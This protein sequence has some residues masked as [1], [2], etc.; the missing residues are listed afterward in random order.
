MRRILRPRLA[1][2]AAILMLAG[3]VFA[4]GSGSKPAAPAAS[5]AAGTVPELPARKDL[6]NGTGS[7]GYVVLAWNDLGMHCLNPSYDA[8]VILPPYNTVV[9]QV[10]KRGNPPQPVTSGLTVSYRILGNTRSSNKGSYGQFWVYAQKLFGETLPLDQGLNLDDPTVH[11]GLSGTMLAKEDHFLASGIPVTPIN[12]QGVWN[13]Y[14]VGEITVKDASGRVLA[15]TTATV[16]TSDE[17]NCAKCHGKDA[18]NEVL[19]QH[20]TAHGTRLFANRPVLC[21]SCHGSPVLGT[22]G[23]GTSGM[24]LSQ[25][26]H[27]SHATRGAACYDCHP[28][29]TTRCSRS[30]AH[31]AA[32]GNCMACHGDMANV[33]NTIKSGT[34]IPWAQ[35]PK[36]VTCHSGVAGV[37]TGMALFRNARGHGNLYCSACHGSAHAMVPTS[38]ASDNAQ[39]IQYT[40]GSKSIGSCAAC[41][42]SNRVKDASEWAHKHTAAGDN[43][44]SACNVCHTGF[45]DP[46]QAKWPHRFQWKTRASGSDDD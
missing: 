42:D 7:S 10:V 3:L 26:I 2:F 18:L 27:G 44:A 33:A 31:T 30:L 32:D 11:N 35:E 41:H 9:A 34:R 19:R 13:P 15:K 43:Q 8:A 38:Q 28:G 23:P 40:G 4:C 5:S 1:A 45:K 16:P 21:A 22:T 39:A 37:D 46:Q 20:D 29:A 24:Y 12:D 36:C 25:A 6:P 17:I 14:Q